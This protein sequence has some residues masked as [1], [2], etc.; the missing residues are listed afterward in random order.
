MSF[1]TSSA[2]SHVLPKLENL[3]LPRA[4]CLAPWHPVYYKLHC[5]LPAGQ[6]SCPRWYLAL[7]PQVFSKARLE[8]VVETKVLRSSFVLS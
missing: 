5:Y 1:R 4:L 6:S 8:Q 3:V 2:S 7:P